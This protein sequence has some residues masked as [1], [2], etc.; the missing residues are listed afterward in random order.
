MVSMVINRRLT[1]R[2]CGL[3]AVFGAWSTLLEQDSAAYESNRNNDRVD[4]RNE[5]SPQFDGEADP[6]D[7]TDR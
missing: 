3:G 5:N 1:R 7:L 2:T 6:E 4:I